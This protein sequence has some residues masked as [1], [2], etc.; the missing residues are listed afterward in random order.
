MTITFAAPEVLLC[1]TSYLGTVRK[2]RLGHEYLTAGWDTRLVER[3][4]AAALAISIVTVAEELSGE[5]SSR[6]G[7]RAR[8]DADAKRR[9]YVWIPLDLQTLERW[10]ILDAECRR[11][12]HTGCDDNDL[13]IAATA[14]ERVL[15]LVTCDK[16]QSELPG[17]PEVIF[18]PA[19][20]RH[21]K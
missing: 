15:P 10:A 9:A 11:T 19:G 2:A 8:A 1:D 3:I 13:W 4:A 18:L 20:T 6:W 12:G 14:I 21:S 7:E 5:I 17:L 16:R